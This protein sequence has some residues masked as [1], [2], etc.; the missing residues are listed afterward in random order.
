VAFRFQH[1]QFQEFYA[2]Q[3]LTNAL[4]EL[5]RHGD[6][7]ADRAFAGAYINKPMWEQSL[8]MIAEDIRL[9]TEDDFAQGAALG[10]GVCLVN[11]ALG[12]DPILA[13]DLSRLCGSLVW[14]SVCDTASIAY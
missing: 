8:R 10:E 4:T 13:A 3:F 12:V 6:E 7:V 2:A 1:Q 5:V 11:L 14:R 9:R